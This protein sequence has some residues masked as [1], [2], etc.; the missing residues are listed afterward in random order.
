MPFIVC[1]CSFSIFV[2]ERRRQ[3]QGKHAP[4]SGVHVRKMQ[5]SARAKACAD[6]QANAADSTAA[7]A[8]VSINKRKKIEPL[9]KALCCR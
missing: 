2:D 6:E 8:A 9:T 1:K 5:V 7:R 3:E 4:A